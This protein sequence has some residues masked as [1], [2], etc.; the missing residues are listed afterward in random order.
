[1][2]ARAAYEALEGWTLGESEHL[3]KHKRRG[4]ALGPLN[5]EPKG[6]MLTDWLRLAEDPIILVGGKGV[7]ASKLHQLAVSK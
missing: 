2:V 6:L 7:F 3:K 1:M 4:Y 5:N